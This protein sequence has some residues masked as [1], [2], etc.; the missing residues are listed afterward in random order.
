MQVL[1]AAEL[2]DCTLFLLSLADI[3]N[4][5][6]SLGTLVIGGITRRSGYGSHVLQE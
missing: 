1:A 4:F 5:D 6:A 2:Y 3:V